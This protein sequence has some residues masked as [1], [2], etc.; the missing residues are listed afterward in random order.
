MA[1]HIEARCTAAEGDTDKEVMFESAWIAV[2]EK[3]DGDWRMVGVSSSV[4]E[5]D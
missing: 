2:Y 4:V 1:I 3:H 5:R